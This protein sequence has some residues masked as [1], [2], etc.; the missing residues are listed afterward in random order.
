LW[1]SSPTRT[2]WSC[3]LS[4]FNSLCEIRQPLPHTQK[5]NMKDF[6]FS[7]WD[8]LYKFNWVLVKAHHCLSILF[9]RFLEDC[10][11]GGVKCLSFQFSLWDSYNVLSNSLEPPNAFNSLC[12]IP[13]MPAAALAAATASS[14]QFSLWDSQTILAISHSRRRAL[15]ILFVRF[16]TKFSKTV[17]KS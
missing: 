12:E 5:Q 11:K 4:S 15:S 14:F 10:E 8:S 2:A 1:D 9:V 13:G 7:L 17:E 16:W 6:Q 3:R